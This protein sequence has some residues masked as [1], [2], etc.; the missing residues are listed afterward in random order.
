MNQ[1]GWM[2]IANEREREREQEMEKERKNGKVS[3]AAAAAL[4]H[5][6]SKRILVFLKEFVN[7]A[8]L[9]PLF[10]FLGREPEP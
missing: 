1:N 8:R 10:E 3:I 5:L 6:S 4:T 9:V 7:L 2:E